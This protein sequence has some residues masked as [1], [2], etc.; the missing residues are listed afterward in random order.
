[1]PDNA[2]W[3]RRNCWII[4]SLVQNLRMIEADKS[5]RWR[6]IRRLAVCLSTWGRKRPAVS[7]HLPLSD[8]NSCAFLAQ[9]TPFFWLG[10]IC[11]TLL[12]LEE[13]EHA[14]RAFTLAVTNI[15]SIRGQGCILAS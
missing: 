2:G 9:H 3:Y 8:D 11:T 15:V 13:S 6:A 12:A 4:S 10:T 14:T 7:L 1:M 5:R